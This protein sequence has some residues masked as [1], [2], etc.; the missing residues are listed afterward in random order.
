MA[1]KLIWKDSKGSATV[2]VY[3]SAADEEF[4]ARLW[5]G[6]SE[7]KGAAYFTD[8]KRDAI[9][10]AKAMLEHNDCGSGSLGCGCT[11]RR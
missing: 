1:K 2:K 7:R 5:C 6:E 8:D 10:T 11:R 4:S 3:W 9:G